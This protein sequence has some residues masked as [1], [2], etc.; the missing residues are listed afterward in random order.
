MDRGLMPF[1][2][3]A[4][5]QDFGIDIFNNFRQPQNQLFIDHSSEFF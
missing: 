4:S 5:L 1:F 2:N 3:A